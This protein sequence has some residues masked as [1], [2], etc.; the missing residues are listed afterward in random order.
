MNEKLI[1]SSGENYPYRAYL[2]TISNYSSPAKKTWL[3][4]FEGFYWDE[5]GEMDADANQGLRT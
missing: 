3:R 5:S 1:Y 4:Q 2:T